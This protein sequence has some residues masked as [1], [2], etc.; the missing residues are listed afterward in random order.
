[1]KRFL[2]LL[3]LLTS[4]V[5]ADSISIRGFTGL[6]NSVNDPLLPPGSSSALVN[7]DLS[8]KI[9]AL[10]RR[11]GYSEAYLAS[12]SV[13]DSIMFLGTGERISGVRHLMFVGDSTGVGYGVLGAT[14]SGSINLDFSQTARLVVTPWPVTAQSVTRYAEW[15][16]NTFAVNGVS[17]GAYYPSN[18]V[19]K[20]TTGQYGRLWPPAAPGELIATPLKQSGGMNGTYRYL[21]YAYGS[22][23]QAHPVIGN[24]SAPVSV[25]NGACIVTNFPILSKDS[26][27]IGVF[28]STFIDVFR[29][30]NDN[31]TI[32]PTD[33]VWYTGVTL[34][35]NSSTYQTSAVSF[36]D[37][38]SDVTLRASSRKKIVRG[39]SAAGYWAYTSPTADT[40]SSKI[41][42][43]QYVG[44]ATVSSDSNWNVWHNAPESLVRGFS[45]MVQTLDP[46]T[47]AVSDSGPTFSI[48]KKAA[49]GVSAYG[50]Q[51]KISLAL[52]RMRDTTLRQIVWRAAVVAAPLKDAIYKLY[53][54]VGYRFLDSANLVRTFYKIGT[55]LPGDTITDSIPYDSLVLRESFR[56]VGPIEPFSDIITH[57]NI[58]Y[59]SAGNRM[60]MS[61]PDTPFNF[62]RSSFVT[63]NESRGSEVTAM[64]PTQYA[65]RATTRDES[66]A[67][68]FDFSSVERISSYGCLSRQGHASS[69][70]VHYYPS[71]EGIVSESEG[72]S[73]ERNYEFGLLT[74]GLANYDLVTSVIKSSSFG[75]W[76]DNKYFL[77]YSADSCLVYDEIA[78]GFSVWTTPISSAVRYGS[79]GSVGS[80]LYD[81]LYFLRGGNRALYRFGDSYRD[82]TAQITALWGSPFIGFDPTQKIIDG[83]DLWGKFGPDSLSLG[84]N[85]YNQGDSVFASSTVSLLSTSRVN[86]GVQSAPTDLFRVSLIFIPLQT[87]TQDLIVNGL[88]VRYGLV[89]R[90]GIDK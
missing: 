7:F 49:S 14:A 47:G 63:L 65:I 29:T 74:E 51:S 16:G 79:G 15:N 42:A 5:F 77:K 55:Y 53:D 25:A 31:G 71:Y 21:A 64:W 1:M 62:L 2:F 26:G 3:T 10:T 57:S 39:I 36:T 75:T 60:W 38:M 69:G 78:K 18:D 11:R 50:G 83:I 81:T 22:T 43:P 34:T 46:E 72:E 20:L 52:P 37:T 68:A 87:P 33:T 23:S 17:R 59:A 13:F 8:D 40:V 82:T 44:R 27:G 84:T 86:V 88:D 66:Y 73:L 4:S 90:R 70:G 61:R 89:G 9:G 85:F 54:T 19:P 45:W 58:L 28:D 24:F 32:D 12:S 56:Q 30:T 48:V 67:V 80:A 76:H 35:V 6:K 41:G